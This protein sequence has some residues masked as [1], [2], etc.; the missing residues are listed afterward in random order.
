MRS[1]RLVL[2]MMILALEKCCLM[3]MNGPS[4]PCLITSNQYQLAPSPRGSDVWALLMLG[5]AFNQWGQLLARC[6]LIDRC[7]V[8]LKRGDTTYKCLVD[9]EKEKTHWETGHSALLLALGPLLLRC[10]I[11]SRSRR[12]DTRWAVANAC[13]AAVRQ[14]SLSFLPRALAIGT[15]SNI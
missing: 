12:L 7:H 5:R 3:R 6:V 9:M 11:V 1:C 10:F 2:E 13:S 15:R 14:W 4:A 8:E